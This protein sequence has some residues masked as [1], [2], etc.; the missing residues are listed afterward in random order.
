M[1]YK[2]GL[3]IPAFQVSVILGSRIGY[4][5]NHLTLDEIK[6]AI[7]ESSKKVKGFTF[8]GILTA[9][10]VLVEG[11]GKKYEEKAYLIQSSIYPRYPVGKK[12]FKKDFSKFIG[13]LATILR[14]ERIIVN[15]SDES[16]IIETK[17]CKNPDL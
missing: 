4:T 15:F 13:E 5:K 12:K 16:F 2:T 10:T 9:T 11:E 8:S 17:Y 6:I 1:T 3:N 7:A 14:Q